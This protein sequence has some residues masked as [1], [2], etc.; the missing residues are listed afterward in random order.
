MSSHPK[1]T[2]KPIENSFR[3]RSL[4]RSRHTAEMRAGEV[5]DEL[6]LRPILA[7][8]RKRAERSGKLFA[9]MLLDATQFSANGAECKHLLQLLLGLTRETDVVGWYEQGSVVGVIFTEINQKNTDTVVETLRTRIEQGLEDKVGIAG[10][11]QS[12]ISIDLFPEPAGSSGSSSSDGGRSASSK[13]YPDGHRRTA[14]RTTPLIIKRAIDILG[15]ALLL[16][17]LSPVFGVIAAA[18]KLT[19]KGEV[20]FKQERLG[21]NGVPFQFLKFRSMYVNNSP[22]IHRE[23]VTDFIQGKDRPPEQESKAGKVYKIAWDPRVTPVGRFLRRSSLDELPQLL[24]VL[25][26]QMSLV[27][28]RPPL[29]YEFHLYAPWHRR[30]IL[31]AKPGITGL[32]QV[33]GRSRTCFDDMVRLDLRYA[34]SWSLWLDLLIL[35][36]TPFVVFSGDGAY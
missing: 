21:H 17:L 33:N 10:V 6:S 27:G 2:E 13:F 5:V 4:F 12:I 30:R 16:V 24:N 25:K 14:G 18:I 9:L 32:W 22:R 35:L 15:S 3:N 23:F 19:S 20:L 29:P 26:G 28:P 36:R 1:I 11:K 8:E 34:R 31:E 7:L